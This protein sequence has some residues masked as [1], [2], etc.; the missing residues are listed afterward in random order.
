[1]GIKVS[2][3]TLTFIVSSSTSILVP[4]EYLLFAFVQV[5]HT[6]EPHVSSELFGDR[7]NSLI[8]TVDRESSNGASSC[9]QIHNSSEDHSMLHIH[10]TSYLH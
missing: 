5:V 3:L 7:T 8:F 9:V 10:M 4:V 6:L 2:N 1:M